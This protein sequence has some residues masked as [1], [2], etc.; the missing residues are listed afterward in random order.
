[1]QKEFKLPDLG[2]SIVSATVVKVLI[3]PGRHG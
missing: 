2:E 3:A 1:M